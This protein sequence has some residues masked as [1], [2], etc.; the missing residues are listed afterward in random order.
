MFQGAT[1]QLTR[2]GDQLNKQQG[3][4]E[5]KGQTKPENISDPLVGTDGTGT[6]RDGGNT[7]SA[8]LP[9]DT[10]WVQSREERRVDRHIVTSYQI[11]RGD[12][13]ISGH[14]EHSSWP[15]ACNSSNSCSATQERIVSQVGGENS[16]IASSSSSNN[17][18][19][20]KEEHQL[21]SRL[22]A[23]QLEKVKDDIY[24][25]LSEDSDAS[26]LGIL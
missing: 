8:S 4:S 11:T 16:S 7:S 18:K 25:L 14:T 19:P 23:R 6:D 2:F 9:P 12:V 10:Q 22:L 20:A 1:V 26:S 15:T 13:T 5:Q 24:R 17:S 3:D 21:P